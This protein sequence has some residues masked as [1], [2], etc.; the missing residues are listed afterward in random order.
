MQAFVL[1]KLPAKQIE[2]VLE[3]LRAIAGIVEASVIYGETD[4]I[5]K[6]DVASQAEL[7]HLVFRQLQAMPAVE[8]TRTFIV[9]GDLHWDRS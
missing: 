7:D 2:T 5:A 9:V 4:V 8:S 1:I 3:D 6:V